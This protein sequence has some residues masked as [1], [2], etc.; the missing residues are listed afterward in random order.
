MACISVLPP[1]TAYYPGAF[2]RYRDLTDGRE[3]QTFGAAGADQLAWA[4][5]RG[6]DASAGDDRRVRVEPFGGTP[7]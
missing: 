5:I 2:D 3:C 6:V 1:R 4:L 7:R